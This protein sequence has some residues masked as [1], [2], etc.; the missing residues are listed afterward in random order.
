MMSNFPFRHNVF[1]FYFMT[2][3]VQS[4]LLQNRCMREKVNT[5]VRNLIKT[6]PEIEEDKNKTNVSWVTFSWLSCSL[7]K[8]EIDIKRSNW[9]LF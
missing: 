8:N 2:K 3:H 7:A 4:R 9:H 5:N 1:H 6:R